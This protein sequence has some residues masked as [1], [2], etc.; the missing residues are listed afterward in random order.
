MKEC[1]NARL[2]P[3]A[4]AAMKYPEGIDIAWVASDAQGNLGVF[5]TAGVG[6]IAMPAMRFLDEELQCPEEM[7]AKLP[8]GGGSDL[9]MD[10]PDTS[11]YSRMADRGFYVFDW[12]DVYA[13]DGF[14]EKYELVATPRN[15]ARTA[16][17]PPEL[18]SA[19][20]ATK[21][22]DINFAATTDVDPASEF[23]CVQ[24]DE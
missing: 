14:L 3:A 23:E 7:I 20:E 19:C 24:P 6:P 21:F 17:L 12:T 4:V 8:E 2:D 16:D 22:A 13:T 18:S 15:P 10:A 5:I 9:L 1:C 11:S